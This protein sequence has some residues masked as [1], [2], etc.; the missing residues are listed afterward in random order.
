MQRICDSACS[1][2]Y[3]DDISSLAPSGAQ[4]DD[5]CH[6][7]CYTMQML[8]FY[9]C[10]PFRWLC[11]RPFG[12]FVLTT[13]CCMA[14]VI[15]QCVMSF[16]DPKI[17]GCDMWL[18]IVLGVDVAIALFN[19]FYA[20]YASSKIGA[21]KEKDGEI[22]RT[23]G[24]KEE[25]FQDLIRHDIMTVVFVVVTVIGLATNLGFFS[26]NNRCWRQSVHPGGASSGLQFYSM[27]AVLIILGWY[28]NIMCCGLGS[29]QKDGVSGSLEEAP[30]KP[31]LAQ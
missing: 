2:C 19:L 11:K 23:T 7:I 13:T 12:I 15:Y 5:F 16:V 9:T 8:L 30:E 20:F 25:N 31:L 22:K 28:L 21:K 29:K 18:K 3:V 1:F 27:S 17:Q 14:W 6:K 24:T 10:S 26:S 4:A